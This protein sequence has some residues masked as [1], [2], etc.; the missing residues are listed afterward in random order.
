MQ[1]LVLMLIFFLISC[2]RT[3]IFSEN[4]NQGVIVSEKCKSYVQLEF[5]I[6]KKNVWICSTEELYAQ[7][8]L[9]MRGYVYKKMRVY[10]IS[11]FSV[12]SFSG[13]R[14]ERVGNDI[15]INSN[16]MGG[17][18]NAVVDAE[19]KIFLGEFIRTFD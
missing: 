11:D 6:P 18:T 10:E 13:L 1:V 2:E 4:T 14:F 5:L 8:G 15:K 9:K 3:E 7:E 16:P 17:E 19:K 12:F